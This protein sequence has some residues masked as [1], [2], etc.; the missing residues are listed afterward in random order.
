MRWETIGG[1]T[2]ETLDELQMGQVLP[3]YFIRSERATFSS[4]PPSCH[5]TSTYHFQDVFTKA[6]LSFNMYF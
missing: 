4:S 6:A 3:T 5:V 2:E 1:G